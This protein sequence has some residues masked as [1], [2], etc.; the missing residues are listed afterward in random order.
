MIRICKLNASKSRICSTESSGGAEMDNLHGRTNTMYAKVGGL[1]TK[2][3]NL[4]ELEMC[5]L[6][7]W[8][9]TASAEL[10]QQCM[11]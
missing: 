9:L 3:L 7:E 4:L 2:E 11:Y 8:N 1:A 5:F 6:I 10:L